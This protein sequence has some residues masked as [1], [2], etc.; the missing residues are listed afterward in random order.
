VSERRYADELPVVVRHE[1]ELLVGAVPRDA[2]AV[3]IRKRVES[4]RVARDFDVAVDRFDVERV[5]AADDDGGAIETL[6]DG[7]LSVP[8]FGEEIV[9]EKRKVVRERVVLRKEVVVERARLEESRLVE[10]IDAAVDE[11]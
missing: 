11:E 6:P 10:R 2:G 7:S 5:P 3:R 8:L 1:E 9:V 4:N